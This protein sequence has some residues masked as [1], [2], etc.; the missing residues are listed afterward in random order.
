MLSCKLWS[1]Y[2]GMRV[3]VALS[4]SPLYDSRLSL[5]SLPM[6]NDAM[7]FMVGMQAGGNCWGAVLCV[8][9]NMKNPSIIDPVSRT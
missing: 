8:L 5:D 6:P 9:G 1:L 2:D 7:T 3:Q 4:L